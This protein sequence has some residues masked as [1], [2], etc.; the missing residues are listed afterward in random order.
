MILNALIF[1][2]RVVNIIEVLDILLDVVLDA[3]LDAV[4]VIN[5]LINVILLYGLAMTASDNIFLR[6][7]GLIK[8]KLIILNTQ[9]PDFFSHLI[10]FSPDLS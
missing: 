5:P 2:N 4:G 3:V 1:S 6:K 8:E 9:N 10:S 7:N